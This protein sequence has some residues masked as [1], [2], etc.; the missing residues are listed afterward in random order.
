[1]NFSYNEML[2]EVLKN[3][4]IIEGNEKYYIVNNSNHIVGTLTENL[5]VLFYICNKAKIWNH[6]NMAAVAIAKDFILGTN[7]EVKK[8]DI[9]YIRGLCGSCNDIQSIDDY[10]IETF[11]NHELINLEQNYQLG[12]FGIIAKKANKY[13][14]IS[15]NL[16]I[17]FIGN[18]YTEHYNQLNLLLL[19]E[20]G[21]AKI[22]YDELYNYLRKEFDWYYTDGYN[23]I[24]S[25][26]KR[27]YV[28]YRKYKNYDSITK[29]IVKKIVK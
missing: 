3:H 26:S 4:K 18:E 5:I 8:V 13:C 19:K 25:Q 16:L 20:K 28:E 12:Y 21:I 23:N 6:K 2:K 27:E 15:N 29:P 17:H 1:M 9:M 14:L 22:N 10:Y 11:T 24:S 7:S